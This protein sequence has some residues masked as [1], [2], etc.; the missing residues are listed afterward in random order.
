MADNRDDANDSPAEDNGINHAN[1]PNFFP[2]SRTA[3]KATEGELRR[4]LFLEQS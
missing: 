2:A 3:L 4:L 1:L